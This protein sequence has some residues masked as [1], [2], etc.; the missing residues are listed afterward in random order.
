MP[1]I[2]LTTFNAKYAHASFGLRYLMANL[3]ELQ[4]RAA[5]VEFEISQRVGDVL[6]AIL[7]LEPK[8]VG[9]GVYIWNIDQ[10]TRLVAD[11]KRL[12]PEI[13]VV[14]GGPEVSYESEQQEIVALADYT[15]A[16]E[17]DLTFARLCHWL[18]GNRDV[19]P[20]I[21][22]VAHQHE[23]ESTSQEQLTPL[24]P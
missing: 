4:S 19:A 6:E 3:G 22:L 17:A 13:V 9:I 12:R 8:I 24:S 16:G 10:S 2:V 1:D 5:I 15:I 11:L 7:A 21:P 14:L 20:F 23:E 18:L